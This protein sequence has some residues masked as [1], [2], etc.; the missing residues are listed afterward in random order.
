MSGHGWKKYIKGGHEFVRTNAILY[1]TVEFK[2]IFDTIN[3]IMFQK[4]I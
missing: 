1:K 2:G 3:D 4:V